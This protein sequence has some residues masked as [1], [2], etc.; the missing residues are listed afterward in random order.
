MNLETELKAA[1]RRR[2]PPPGFAT[3]VVA[4][5]VPRRRT[6]IAVWAAALAAMLVGGIAI[7]QEYQQK[8]AEKATEQALLGPPGQRWKGN[9]ARE[10][11]NL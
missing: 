9:W 7:N 10:D 2:N 1:L 4:A 11:S 8:R 6:P 3:R 5:A